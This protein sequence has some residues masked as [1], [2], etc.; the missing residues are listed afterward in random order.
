LRGRLPQLDGGLFITDGGLETT[1]IFDRGIELPLFAAFPL[2]DD[3]NG[4]RALRAYYEPYLAVAERHGAGFILDAPTWRAS[5]RWAADLGISEAELERLNRRAIELLEELRSEHAG[6]LSGPTVIAGVLG[7]QDDGYVPHA[8]LSAEQAREY[9][10]AQ[11]STFADTAAD[12]VSAMTLTYADE[13]IGIALAAVDAGIP[14]AISFTVETD[15]RLPSGQPLAD[16]IDA[17]E[18]A[19]QGAP[20]YYMINCAHPTH[21]EDVLEPGAPWA[22]RVLGVRANASTRSHAELDE[23]TELDRGDPA[24]L[25]RRYVELAACLPRMNVLGGC[26]GTSGEHVAAIAA[27]WPRAASGET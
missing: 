22:Q 21:F 18:A 13:A 6:R 23:A 15:G 7:P 1:L 24:D 20:A 19:T 8:L 5:S 11:I 10:A 2:V 16:A 3:E 17:V 12:L 25:G 9:H 14:A 27:D 4:R 26:C